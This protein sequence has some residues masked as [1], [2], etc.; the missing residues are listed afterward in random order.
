V[1][2]PRDDEG[3]RFAKNALYSFEQLTSLG[4]SPVIFV[5][6]QKI[7]ELYPQLTAATVHP[8]ENRATAALLHTFNRLSGSDSEH[9]TFDRADFA[10]CLDSGVITFAADNITQWKNPADISTA[11]RDR[12][13][14]NILASV[15][16]SKATVAA[17]L[18]VLSGNTYESVESASL[19]HGNAMF[20]RM[21]ANGSTVF[22]GVYKGSVAGPNLIKTLAMIGSLPWPRQRLLELA[23]IAGVSDTAAAVDQL[24]G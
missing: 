23:R 8:T 15:D 21:L 18:Y 12:L 2:L 22:P 11:I 5:D 19:D 24:L 13:R 1:A 16:F 14:R 9:T 7:R 4:L 20:T 17:L 6:N 3:Q 10:K